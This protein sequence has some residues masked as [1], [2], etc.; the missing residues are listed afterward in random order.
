MNSSSAPMLIHPMLI[1]AYTMLQFDVVLQ[2]LLDL[3][4]RRPA[5]RP[6]APRIAVPAAAGVY[7]L[8]NHTIMQVI[9]T[10]GVF[11]PDVVA[12]AVVQQLLGQLLAQCRF[13]TTVA[14]E[15][16]L[17]LLPVMLPGS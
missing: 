13:G 9:D 1:A 7:R 2:F 14:H 15:G 3:A 10:F 16:W 4:R 12:N 17:G 11:M 8:I 6:I 5:P